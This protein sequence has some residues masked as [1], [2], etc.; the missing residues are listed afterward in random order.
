VKGN[1]VI[2]RVLS[3]DDANGTLAS[4]EYPQIEKQFPPE[5]SRIEYSAFSPVAG[6]LV[7]YEIR[8]LQGRKVI[9]EMKVLEITK[10]TQV[11]SAL[12]NAPANAELWAQCDDMQE[13]ELID[14]VPPRY[15]ASARAHGQDGRVIL[16][17]VIEADGSD[18]R[19]R[20][21][22]GPESRGI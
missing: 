16:Y 15:P 13:A 11:N 22:P 2:D 20:G 7:P 3:F 5:I 8:A 6:K 17:A 1:R 10:I 18:N 12:F 19:S 14:R 4:I 21:V 9:A